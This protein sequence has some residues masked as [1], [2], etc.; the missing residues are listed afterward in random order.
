MGKQG[1]SSIR[2]LTIGELLMR[3]DHLRSERA[4]AQAQV[5]DSADYVAQF[6][7]WA[8]QE[9]AHTGWKQ[10]GND[11]ASA[12]TA[13]EALGRDRFS[14]EEYVWI[15]DDMAVHLEPADPAELDAS[16]FSEEAEI[17]ADPENIRMLDASAIEDEN[18]DDQRW[19]AAPIG[20]LAKWGI[21]RYALAATALGIVA[22]I[23]AGTA[24]HMSPTEQS[25]NKIASIAAMAAGHNPYDETPM[26]EQ[27]TAAAEPEPLEVS[28]VVRPRPLLTPDQLDE[29]VHQALADQG[30]W[31]IGVSAGTRGDVYL[32]GDVYSLAEARYVKAV[33][34]H[35]ARAAQVYF[36]HP[37][38]VPSEGPAY[39]GAVAAYAPSVWGAEISGVAI[40]SPAYMAGLRVGDVIRGFDHK[41]IA[42]AKD[43][44]RAIAEHQPGQRIQ[45]R[46]WR[47]N[48]NQFLTVRLATR[49]TTEVAMR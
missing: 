32:A 2:Y 42:D 36:P 25:S 47:D 38:V 27:A 39:F 12:R 11:A 23:I 10:T 3:I 31:D 19:R 7:A 6:E 24:L 20:F 14:G 28:A 41:T 5:A 30:F 15:G 9:S 48:A 35:A 29:R 33:A 16:E 17:A 22:L 13:H 49:P 37:Q 44:N 45:I 40:G 18:A 8:A 4:H 26:D 1:E 43:L 34:R 46:V 21:E